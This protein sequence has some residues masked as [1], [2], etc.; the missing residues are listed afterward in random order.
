MRD[1][2]SVRGEID[3][4]ISWDINLSHAL[5]E[6]TLVSV[7]GLLRS[8]PDVSS[9]QVFPWIVSSI[10]SYLESK[11]GST[12]NI[13]FNARMSTIHSDARAVASPLMKSF[14][15]YW[16]KHTSRK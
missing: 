16:I 3:R 15:F 14:A 13:V 12:H 4:R 5:T 8:C 10:R 6:D 2:E 11:E 9:E 1:L 7:V